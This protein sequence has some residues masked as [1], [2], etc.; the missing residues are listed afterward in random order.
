MISVTLLNGKFN[1]I[2]CEMNNKSV[3][4]RSIDIEVWSNAMQYDAYFELLEKLLAEGKTTGPEQTPERLE[5]AK[6]NLSRMKRIGQQFQTDDES[7]AL[8]KTQPDGIK[9][10]FIVE[11]WCGDAAQI[12]PALEKMLQ[13]RGWESR[14]ILRDE[15]LEI[16]DMFL[17]NGARA[18]PAVVAIDAEGK[19]LSNHWGPRPALLKDLVN[20]WKVEMS[21]DEWHKLLHTW[22]AKDKSGTLQM[23]FASWVAGLNTGNQ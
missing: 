2:C 10:L 14:Y 1:E 13:A 3:E 23:D 18:I 9:F 12:V 17:T 20:H 16:M 19:V 8:L 21:K 7:M 5:H 6:L 4:S 22:Y 15:H 11:G